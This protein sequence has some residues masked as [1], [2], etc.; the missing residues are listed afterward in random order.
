[1]KEG[2]LVEGIGLRHIDFNPDLC[3]EE[4]DEG[5]RD[6]VVDMNKEGFLTFTSCQG[7]EGHA[8]LSPFIG[9]FPRKDKTMD[10]ERRAIIVFLSKRGDTGYEV[11]QCYQVRTPDGRIAAEAIE[12]EFFAKGS[13]KEPS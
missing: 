4:I 8:F 5:I 11:K 9:L 1:M 10:E 3:P 13:D 7:G 6:L 12:L 2:T